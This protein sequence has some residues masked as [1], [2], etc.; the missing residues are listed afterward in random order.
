MDHRQKTAFLSEELDLILVFVL[1]VQI[2]H[3]VEESEIWNY[4]NYIF[5]D[6]YYITSFVIQILYSNLWL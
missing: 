2:F 6:F 3:C 1:T 4:Q 5:I